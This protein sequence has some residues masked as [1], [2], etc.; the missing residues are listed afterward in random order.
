MVERRVIDIISNYNILYKL[1]QS[2]D[3]RP[4]VLRLFTLLPLVNLH[5]LLNYVF[6]F[7]V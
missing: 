4:F 5:H 3:L 6:S 7:S 2:L 1:H